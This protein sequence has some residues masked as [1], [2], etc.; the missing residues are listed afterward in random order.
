MINGL[1][2]KQAREIKKLTQTELG[3]RLG[4]TQSAVGKIEADFRDLDQSFVERLAFQTGFPTSF[5]YQG[6]VPDFPLGTFLFRC[7]AKLAANEKARIRQLSLLQYEIQEKLAS[8]TI[9]I[10]LHFPSF[11]SLD[12]KEAA[13]H[14]RNALGIPPDVPIPNLIHKLEKNGVSVFALSNTSAEFDAFSL[15]SDGNPRRPIV[16]VN[17]DKPADR[18]RLTCAHELAHLVMHRSPRGTVKELEHDAQRFA[19]EFLMPSDALRK[20]IQVPISLEN[21]GILKKRWGVSIQAL[22]FKAKDLELISDRQYRYLF[23]QISSL[24]WRKREPP[25]FDIKSEKPRLLRKLVELK[26]GMEPDIRS[27]ARLVSIPESWVE[28][29]LANYADRAELPIK[30]IDEDSNRPTES[31]TPQSNVIAFKRNR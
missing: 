21:L 22:I 6:G 20:E 4:L 5:F 24:G 29:M 28:P 2:V 12:A 10:P 19:S 9:P 23:E 25:Q 26:F 1:R 7:R 14:T 15:W 18:M 16:V 3:K 8:G 11:D 31:K 17:T 30:Q 13:A 27:I